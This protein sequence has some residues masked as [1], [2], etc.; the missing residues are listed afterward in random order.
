MNTPATFKRCMD[1]CLEDVQ[2]NICVPYLD[3]TL[4]YIQSF[5]NQNMPG[6]FSSCLES[7][8]SIQS[9]ANVKYFRMKSST[10]EEL[11]KPKKAK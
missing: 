8:G 10:W 3:D 7:T 1:E 11:F 5:G 2:D 9:Q 6:K 4:V